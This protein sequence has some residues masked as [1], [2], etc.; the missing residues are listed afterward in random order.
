LVPLPIPLVLAPEARLGA[1]LAAR[2]R[3]AVAARIIFFTVVSFFI[4]RVVPFDA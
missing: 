4:E 2:T 3:A 1:A